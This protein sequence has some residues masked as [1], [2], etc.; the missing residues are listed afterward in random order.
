MKNI[1]KLM[2]INFII[3]SLSGIIS[4][5]I[6][7]CILYNFVYNRYLT[8]INE[9]NTIISNTFTE[10]LQLFSRYI[11]VG[12][13]FMFVYNYNQT[14]WNN[15]I[16]LSALE[17]SPYNEFLNEMRLHYNISKNERQNYENYMKKEIN[18]DFVIKV[19]NFINNTN[20][21]T[22]SQEKEFYLP[23]TYLS[24]NTTQS[25]NQFIGVDILQAN[26]YNEIFNNT[27]NSNNTVV[28]TSRYVV[29]RDVYTLDISKKNDRGYVIVTIVI[30]DL[31]KLLFNNIKQFNTNIYYKVKI[32]DDVFK[33]FKNNEKKEFI[34]TEKDINIKLKNYEID[35]KLFIY[36]NNFT[37][38]LLEYIITALIIY[39]L[40][41]VMIF[42]IIIENK[43]K[44][45][46][47]REMQIANTM[48]SYINHE[49][50]NPLNVIKGLTEL[51]LE[52]IQK[53]MINEEIISNMHTIKNACEMLEHIVNDS[54][55]INKIIQS[56]FK[57]VN[58]KIKLQYFV[59]DIKKIVNL[60]INEKPQIKVQVINELKDEY[61]YG[62]ETR[63]KQIIFNFVVNAIKFTEGGYIK[64]EIKEEDMERIRISVE[65]TG[66]GIKEEDKKRIFEPYEQLDIKDSL[67]HGGLGLGLYLCKL[68]TKL[69]NGEIG[70]K[71]E[72]E[73]GSCF[74]IVINKNKTSYD[75]K[76]ENSM[77]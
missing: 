69:M 40:I 1:S 8:M 50:R 43:R 21:L 22:T 11:Y 2:I 31:L 5:I 56:K 25:L 29:L 70:F 16:E 67:R 12:E 44:Q 3:L 7:Y 36:E 64:I 76:N 53:S 59:Q 72:E 75:N 47:K 63:L 77:V 34:E 38:N 37:T 60:K 46:K 28:Y 48:L 17:Y 62:D 42:K 57:L 24:P 26:T 35:V 18:P 52:E 39:I 41:L 49:I 71:S 68:L 51:N 54:L 27:I 32:L 33:N 14:T 9:E 66:R 30:D 55:D 19:P 61:I 45:K 6:L 74:Y 20:I 73:K 23:I 10:I 65:D 4:S 13:L 15:F 58:E